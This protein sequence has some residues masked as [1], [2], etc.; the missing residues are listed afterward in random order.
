[1][2]QFQVLGSAASPFVRTVLVMV[3]EVGMTDVGFETVKA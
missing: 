2:A 1:M 3:K